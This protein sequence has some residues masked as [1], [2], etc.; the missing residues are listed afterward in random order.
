MPECT[1]SDMNFYVLNQAC[2]DTYDWQS[3]YDLCVLRLNNNAAVVRFKFANQEAFAQAY[4]DWVLGD[5]PQEVARYY[6]NLYGMN[7]VEYHY[8]VL[9][10]MKTIY[11]MF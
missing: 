1:A 8:G 2:F 11:Y 7:Q 4:Q 5:A 10:N 3:V 6:M 9:E